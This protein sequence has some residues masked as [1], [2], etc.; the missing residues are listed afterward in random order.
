MESQ[1]LSTFM[2]VFLGVLSVCDPETG[3]I[4]LD[5]P[6]RKLGSTVSEWVITYL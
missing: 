3:V 2:T 4:Y 6:G 1:V 5:V